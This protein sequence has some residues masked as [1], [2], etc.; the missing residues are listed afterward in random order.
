MILSRAVPD[1]SRDRRSGDQARALNAVPTEGR[2][3]LRRPT[4]LLIVALG[5]M[6]LGALFRVRQFA[7]GRSLWLD[8]AML[9][10]NITDRS[11]GELMGPLE[12]GQVAPPGFLTTEKI[13]VDVFGRADWALRLFPFLAALGALPLM[14][15]VAKQYNTDSGTILP[16]AFFTLSTSLTYYASEVK[17]YSIEV[18]VALVLLWAAHPC[19]D[20]D[21]R[22]RDFVLLGLLGCV[23]LVLSIPA[24]FTLA[25]IGLGVGLA[26]IATRRKWPELILT[27]SMWAIVLAVMYMVSLR[28]FA[29]DASLAEYWH[30][31]FVTPSLSGIT[32][33]LA[34]LLADP[35]GLPLVPVS[36][37]V[38]FVGCLSMM[39]RR[40]EYAVVLIGP[41]VLTLAAALFGK[42]P[43]RGRLL[44]FLLPSILLLI[45]DG[46]ERLRVLF[47]RLTPTVGRLVWMALVLLM[48]SD[49]VL[50][51]ADLFLQPILRE[52]IVPVMQYVSERKQAGDAV[53]VY[54]GAVP[55]FRFYAPRI[56]FSEHDYVRGVAARDDPQRYLADVENVRATRETGRLWLVFAHNC[57]WC[58]VNEQA[59]FLDYLE[60]TGRK[61]DEFLGV[62]AEAY[63]YESRR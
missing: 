49:P 30:T 27:L 29:T 7:A 32:S 59:F 22:L 9:A 36:G 54:Y 52:H 39:Q 25:G 41:T 43:F 21:S 61:A 51:A 48:I 63:L 34:G 47:Q 16:L 11:F 40:R 44:L 50:A 35:L 58:A 17:Q 24:L 33:A 57:P 3:A 37:A 23:S 60:R 19:L 31:S 55:A 53:Y 42:Y 56:G 20:P 4:Y 18:L 8:E 46:L 62:G 28:R 2:P 15:R 13:A 14:Y 38:L 12:Y 26:V 10:I 6:A 5:L 45:G 1:G